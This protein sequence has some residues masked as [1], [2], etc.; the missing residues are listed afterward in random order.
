M[1]NGSVAEHI[2]EHVGQLT[3]KCFCSRRLRTKLDHRVCPSPRASE[4]AHSLKEWFLRDGL[5]IAEAG[6]AECD[7]GEVTRIDGSAETAFHH[8]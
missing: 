3:G 4:L 5:S 6:T 8:G 7:C 2:L 1:S